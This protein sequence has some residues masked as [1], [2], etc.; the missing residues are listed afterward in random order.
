MDLARRLAE[1][2]QTYAALGPEFLRTVE[3]AA[4]L[5]VGAL[6]GGGGVYLAGNGGSAA[7]AQHWAAELVGRYLTE[8]EPLNVHALTVNSSTYTALVNDY[9]PEKVF[10]R[11]VLAHVR[12]G[13]L[14]VA[15]STS[16][17]SRNILLAAGAARSREAKVL[18][19]TG[20]SG[21][22][23]AAL[24]DV[25]LYAPSDDTPRIQEVHLLFGH[26]WCELIERNFAP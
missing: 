1:A 9:P 6:R 4:A 25:V 17:N 20:R 26:L 15:I 13:D 11:Q 3:Q 7:D 10:E 18:G 23:L 24:C 2:Q 12:R 21:G 5:A 14:F 22:K 19:V 8:R 16:G